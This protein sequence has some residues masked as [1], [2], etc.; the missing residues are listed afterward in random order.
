MIFPKTKLIMKARYL[1]ISKRQKN[2]KKIFTIKAY[3]YFGSSSQ[4]QKQI[5]YPELK[6]EYSSKS[7]A[8]KA[9]KKIAKRIES[10]F[11]NVRVLTRFLND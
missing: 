3:E 4:R 7:E 1:S 11:K 9:G 5:K 8:I 10:R 2:K 6:E